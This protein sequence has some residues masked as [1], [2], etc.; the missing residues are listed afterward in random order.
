MINGYTNI[1]DAIA[2]I[3][4]DFGIDVFNGG[5]LKEIM[6]VREL[7]YNFNASNATKFD[8]GLDAKEEIQGM[9]E[10]YIQK[11]LISLCRRLNAQEA[12]R[13]QIERER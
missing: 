2:T 13:E 5:S 8:G 10:D 11:N 4:R 7:V 3:C 12:M 6:Q 1:P 9:L